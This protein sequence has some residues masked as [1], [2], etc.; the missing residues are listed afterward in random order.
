MSNVKMFKYCWVW[1]KSRPSGFAQ[2]KNMPMKDY[3][4]VVVFSDGVTVHASQSKR[5]MPYNPQG[6]VI[7]EEPKVYEKSHIQTVLLEKRLRMVDMSKKRVIT[8]VKF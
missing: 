3:E 1:H 4:D 7:F 8:H 2:A 5:R 6:V